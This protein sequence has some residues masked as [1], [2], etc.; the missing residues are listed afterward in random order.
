MWSSRTASLVFV[1]PV[2]GDN[3]IVYLNIHPHWV[4]A[5]GYS[6]ISTGS[7]LPPSNDP[8]RWDSASWLRLAVIFTVPGCHGRREILIFNQQR[9]SP[10]LTMAGNTGRLDDEGPDWIC[11]VSFSSLWWNAQD[12]Q[13]KKGRGLPRL[14]FSEISAHS[15]SGS[16]VLRALLRQS[17]M[18]GVLMEHSCSWLVSQETERIKG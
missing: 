4:G 2:C 12:D 6:H 17:V 8:L 3:S 5:G 14:L 10:R 11:L 7:W 13:F 1:L 16:I 9:I 18:V 15:P